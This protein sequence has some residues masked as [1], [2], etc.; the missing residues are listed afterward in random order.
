VTQSQPHHPESQLLVGADLGGR[1]ADL[2]VEAGRVAELGTRLRPRLAE[3]VIDAR[4]GALLPGLHDHHLHLLALAAAAR[5]VA[6][7]PPQVRSE[8]ELRAAL[9]AAPGAPGWLRGVGYHESVAGSLDRWRLDAWV[10][11]RPARVQHRSGALWIVNSKALAELRIDATFEGAER[12]ARGRLNGRLLRADRILRERLP[13]VPAD[14]A[15][16]GE[17]LAH[18]GVTGVTDAGAANGPEELALLAAAA[19]SGALPQRLTVMGTMELP[20]PAS[21]SRLERGALKI[22]IDEWSPTTPE[23]LALRV[24][25]AHEAHR[26]VAFHCVTRSDLFLALAALDDA[27]ALRGDRIEHA[28]V[29]P[30]EALPRLAAQ[31]VTVVTQPG[32]VWER[33]DDY[34]RDVSPGDLPW[35][36]R[37]RA[38]DAAGIPL[39]AGTDAPYGEPDPWLAM[40]AAV[41]RRTRS[42]APLGPD[43]AITPERALALFSAPLEA[44]GG[45]PR[46]I[47]PGV[48]ADLCLLR[49]PW[50]EAREQLSRELVAASV[51]GGRVVWRAPDISG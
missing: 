32:F 33:G 22:L 9:A 11:E 15:P 29:A 37:L 20:L 21:G 44:P 4:G 12:D 38:F 27:G 3:P 28:S 16:V 19:A 8:G 23:A 48:P 40:R 43:E 1:S 45:A 34:R 31:G 18:C 5:S 30:P 36:Y 51:I 47:E 7:G 14:L 24:A 39:A 35:L 41:D 50:R 42:G 17:R 26:P 2:R 46:R 25:A 13:S 6:C 10:P 49:L